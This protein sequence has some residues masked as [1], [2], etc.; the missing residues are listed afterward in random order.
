MKLIV[1]D[2]HTDRHEI[3]ASEGTPAMEAI[4]DAGLPIAAQCGGCASCATC[5]VYVDESWLD[6]LPPASEIELAMLEMAEGLMPNSRLS[7]QIAMTSDLD[8]LELKLAP[9]TEY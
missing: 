9:G 2:Q 6:K 3:G 4:R 5:H 1:I 7:C 8:C